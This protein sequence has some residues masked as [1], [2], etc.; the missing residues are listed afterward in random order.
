MI[1][2]MDRDL[3]SRL[4]GEIDFRFGLPMFMEQDIA[5]TDALASKVYTMRAALQREMR[6]NGRVDMFSSQERIDEYAKTIRDIED[7][8]ALLIG[9]MSMVLSRYY[10]LTPQQKYD[11]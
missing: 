4:Q 11:K 8:E 9:Q 2:V 6:K 5:A 7:Q 10:E 3:P 1:D